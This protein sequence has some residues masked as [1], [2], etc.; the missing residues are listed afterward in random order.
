MH[1]LDHILESPIGPS[2]KVVQLP[3]VS[4]IP[5]TEWRLVRLSLKC[6]MAEPTLS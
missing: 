5:K 2:L 4:L 1:Y 3:D 6:S